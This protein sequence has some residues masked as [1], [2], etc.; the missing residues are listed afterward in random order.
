MLRSPQLIQ[1]IAQDEDI[2]I[3]HPQCV[4]L[5]AQLNRRLSPEYHGLLRVNSTSAKQKN[6]LFAFPTTMQKVRAFVGVI[7]YKGGCVDVY[8]SDRR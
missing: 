3:E 1:R 4:A 6:Y 2:V 8:F 7:V 5:T